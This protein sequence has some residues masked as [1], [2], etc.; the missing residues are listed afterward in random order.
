MMECRN[1]TAQLFESSAVYAGD[2]KLDN[3]THEQFFYLR[4]PVC[5]QLWYCKR[6]MVLTDM[7]IKEAIQES[8]ANEE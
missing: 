3:N 2:N 1:C 6:I 7:E 5:G 8:W 4:C